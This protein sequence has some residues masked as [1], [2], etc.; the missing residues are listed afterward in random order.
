[1]SVLHAHPKWPYEPALT[2]Q[3]FHIGR[4]VLS[5]GHRRGD[6]LNLTDAEFERHHGFIQWAFPTPEKSYN[7]FSAPLLDLGTAIWLS[8]DAE[9][10]RF[11]EGMAVR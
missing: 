9:T 10:I 5:S 1:M 6:L 2:L 11:L 3:N 7:N 8:E 4:T